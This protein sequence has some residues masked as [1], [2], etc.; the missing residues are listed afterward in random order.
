[1]EV[2]ATRPAPAAR[3]AVPADRLRPVRVW[4][5]C[6]AAL[7]LLMVAVGGITRLTDSGLSITEWKPIDGAIP[8]LGDADWQAAFKAYR[9]TTEYQVQ[10]QGMTLGQFQFIYWWEWAHRFLGRFIGVAFAVPFL[11]F[12]VMRRIPGRLAA[13]LFLIFV[14][15]GLQGALGWWMVQSGLAG[16]VDV[17]PYRLALHL[18]AAA[19][20]FIAIVSA[21]RSIGPPKPET[22]GA[23]FPLVV[24]LLLVL[25]QIVLGAAVAGLDAGMLHNTWPLMD[26]RVIPRGMG[27]VTPG[28]RDVFE[29]PTT[30]QF[31][32]RGVAYLIVVYVGIVALAR[33]LR[34]DGFAGAHGWLPVIGFLVLLQAAF[35]IATVLLSVPMAV[36]I[37]HQSLAFMLA[38]AT[39]AYLT[40]LSER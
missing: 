28:W 16:N 34:R 32:H 17:S 37:G 39:A 40:D 27:V 5:Y 38:G 13:P 19:L 31:V 6:I 36:A 15:G 26:G 23:R 8:P 21:A 2:V 12:L 35:G 3:A 14:L 29:N 20:L 18:L 30:A 7:V 24:L 10:N 1:M 25:A 11:V 9:G 4:L 33:G 22:E